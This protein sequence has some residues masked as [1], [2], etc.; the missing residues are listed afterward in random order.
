MSL[1][2]EYCFLAWRL[3]GG[4]GLGGCIAVACYTVFYASPTRG[5]LLVAFDSADSGGVLE[6]VI[7]KVP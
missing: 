2:E 5:S 7:L 1:W 6:F 4:F 3:F